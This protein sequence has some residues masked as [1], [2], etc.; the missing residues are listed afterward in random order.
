MHK[1]TYYIVQLGVI[2][3]ETWMID[4]DHRCL[5]QTARLRFWRFVDPIEREEMER[6]EGLKKKLNL[7]ENEKE[8]GD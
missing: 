1:R 6:M 3:Q 2:L 7:E 4:S 8:R 5:E